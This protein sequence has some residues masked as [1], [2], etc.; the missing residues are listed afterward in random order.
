MAHTRSSLLMVFLFSFW[1]L[2]EASAVMKLMNSDTHSCK[3]CLILLTKEQTSIFFRASGRVIM[4]EVR[5]GGAVFLLMLAWKWVPMT[6]SAIGVNWGTVSFHKLKPST[7]VELL[8]DNKIPKV[9]LF[10]AEHAV[11]KALMGSGI[12]VMVGIPNEML[13]LLSSS[14][15]ASDLWV[16]QNVSAYMGKGGADIRYVAVG[17]EPFL[18]SYN[19]QFENLVVPA[20]QNLQQSLVKA[21]LARSIKL[22]VP[23]NADAYGATVPSQ[24]AFRPELTQIMTQIVEFLNSNGAPFMVN[25]YPF[26]SLY[27]DG[28]FPQDY[29]F[30]E[31]TTHPVT[32]GF[33]VY[34]NVFDGNYDTL[35]AALSKLGYGHMP[36]VIGEIGWPSDGAIGANLTAAKVFNQGLINHVLNNKGTPLRPGSSPMDIYLFSLLDEGAKSTLPGGFERHSGIFYFDGKAKY[37]T[38]DTPEGNDSVALDLSSMGKGEAWVNGQSI[39]RYWIMFHD[40]KGKPS[41][42]LVTVR[43]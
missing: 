4:L 27:G 39:G 9:K 41:Q 2:S 25:I 24:G 17:N 13:P 38:F 8:K 3:K 28:D 34:T 6:E 10:E 35:L 29:A 1:H 21:N 32:D 14:P 31:G 33:N 22:V 15:A 40:S 20:I 30:F 36:I 42:S 19:G 37:T 26:L 23:C 5:F 12:Q 18:K 7:V 43:R 11:L 16:H